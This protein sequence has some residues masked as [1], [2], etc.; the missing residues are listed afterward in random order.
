[1][2]DPI[3]EAAAMLVAHPDPMVRLVAE[4]LA[5]ARVRRRA[6]LGTYRGVEATRQ[7]APGASLRL[8]RSS[9]KGKAT[10][11][12]NPLGSAAKLGVPDQSPG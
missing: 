7:A 2:S 10:T 11:C 8:E 6:A 1:M 12:Y 5:G 3:I 4:R 9:S